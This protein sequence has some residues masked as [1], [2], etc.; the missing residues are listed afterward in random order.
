MTT[1]VTIALGP[2]G[3]M[4]AEGRVIGA[5]FRCELGNSTLRFETAAVAA[6]ASLPHRS[7]GRAI[8]WL[9]AELIFG[10]IARGEIPAKMVVTGR[11]SW[12]QD[13]KPRADPHPRHFQEARPRSH[14]AM[15]S[16]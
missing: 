16:C 5:A 12:L 11:T 7:L 2:E 9:N 8:V 4:A 10:R 3:G 6:V 15:P 1:P 14:A 13:L